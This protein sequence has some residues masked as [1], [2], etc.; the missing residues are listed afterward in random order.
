VDLREITLRLLDLLV[1]LPV[2]R[3]QRFGLIGDEV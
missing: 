1:E 3:D 2:E